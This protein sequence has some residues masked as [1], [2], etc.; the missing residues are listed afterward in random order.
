MY[1]LLIYAGLALVAGM[2]IAFQA[3]LNARLAIS[4]GNEPM[5]A[6]TISFLVGTLFLLVITLISRP[7]PSWSVMT[8]APW[9]VWTGGFLGAFFVSVGILSVPK[10]GVAGLVSLVITGQLIMALI[11]DQVGAFGLDTQPITWVRMLG[12]VFLMAGVVMVRFV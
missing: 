5:W 11:L 4:L 10:L 8:G 9:W 3:P 7:V 2:A 12:V 1:G 6:A